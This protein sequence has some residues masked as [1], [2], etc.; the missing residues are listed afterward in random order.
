MAWNEDNK[1]MEVMTIQIKEKTEFKYK[2]FL[3]F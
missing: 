3:N 1:N 2:D